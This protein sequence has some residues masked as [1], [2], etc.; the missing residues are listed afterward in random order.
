M[1]L[2]LSRNFHA[3]V[4]YCSRCKWNSELQGKAIKFKNERKLFNIL[5][6]FKKMSVFLLT[7]KS[8]YKSDE[9]KE[10][11]VTDGIGYS[12]KTAANVDN[13]QLTAG[14]NWKWM[15]RSIRHLRHWDISVAHTDETGRS[16]KLS[17]DCG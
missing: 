8:N 2:I 15:L 5:D 4:S 14:V 11:F 1:H 6:W 7:D 17:I 13:T 10:S 12:R 16:E 3:A 9:I